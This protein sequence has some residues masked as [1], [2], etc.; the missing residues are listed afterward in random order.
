MSQR[1][2]YQFYSGRL[3]VFDENYEQARQSLGFALAHCHKQAKTNKA[4]VLK[5]LVP[6]QLVL[7]RL[8]ALPAAHCLQQ[9]DPIVAA[10]RNGDVKLFDDAMS[11]QQFLFIQEGTYLLLEKL[12]HAVY[13]R[14]LRKVHA[15][16]AV[17]EPE[18]R[19]QVPLA[20]F[21]AALA[22]QGV[23]MSLDE[24]ECVTANLIFKR[25]VKAYISHDRKIIVL[26]K[27][28]PFPPLHMIVDV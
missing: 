9:Y 15:V 7:G 26:A 13:R 4:L 10:M 11:T 17:L 8:P 14:L 21:Q 20:Q 1:V 5:Y 16:H 3:A 2:T 18:K 12:R 23:V 6:V 22:I 19:T 27:K 28:E 25:Y 24:V